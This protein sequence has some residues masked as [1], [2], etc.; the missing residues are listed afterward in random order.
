MC[1]IL[2]KEQ[3]MPE[4]AFLVLQLGMQCLT[5]AEV[6]GRDVAAIVHDV[7]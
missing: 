4:D 6:C 2:S 3:F 7:K 5:N 1:W